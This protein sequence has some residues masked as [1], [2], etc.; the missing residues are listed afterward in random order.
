[1]PDYSLDWTKYAPYFKDNTILPILELVAETEPKTLSFIV[2]DWRDSRKKTFGEL[3][4]TVGI[5]GRHY[6]RWI[7]S[8]WDFLASLWEDGSQI[9]R[10]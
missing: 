10:E 9:G 7:F 1:M 4:K 2:T 5:L 6:C 8:T 3:L